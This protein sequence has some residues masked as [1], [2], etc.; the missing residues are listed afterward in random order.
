VL[1][2]LGV[3]EDDQ[4]FGVMKI[5]IYLSCVESDLI[6]VCF[7]HMSKNRGRGGRCAQQEQ[8]APK[9]EVAQ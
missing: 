8:E 7:L 2:V 4:L 3:S 5:S 9:E 6:Y 1:A